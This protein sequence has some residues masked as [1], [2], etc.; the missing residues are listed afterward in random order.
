MECM[1]TS[2]ILANSGRFLLVPGPVIPGLVVPEPEVR[3]LSMLAV[4]ELNTCV[5]WC[6]GGGRNN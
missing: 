1:P 3:R 5:T 6:E 4:V 2:Q